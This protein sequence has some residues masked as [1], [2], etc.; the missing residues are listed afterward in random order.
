MVTL[1]LIQHYVLAVSTDLSFK[2]SLKI[3]LETS[4]CSFQLFKW[5]LHVIPIFFCIDVFL[6]L[7]TCVYIYRAMKGH[8]L[9]HCV[10]LLLEM[11]YRGQLL[12]KAIAHNEV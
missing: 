11:M 6:I 3:T 7:Y 5:V 10:V 9:E 12:V 4:N 2:D 1:Y 8:E